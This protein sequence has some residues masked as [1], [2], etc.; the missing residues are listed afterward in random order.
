MGIT[1]Y[2]AVDFRTR[3]R[4]PQTADGPPRRL[5][6]NQLLEATKHVKSTFTMTTKNRT[7]NQ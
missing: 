1:R 5:R 6:S 3:L 7:I 4:F 2:A